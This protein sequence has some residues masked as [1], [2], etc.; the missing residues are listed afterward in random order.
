MRQARFLSNGRIEV[1]EVPLPIPTAGEVLLRVLR[2]A[3]CGSEL[4]L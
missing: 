4:R 1:G 3:L 2:C